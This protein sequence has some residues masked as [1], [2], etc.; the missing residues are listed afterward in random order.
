MNQLIKA[1]TILSIFF[2][3]HGCSSLKKTNYGLILIKDPASKK[4][5]V[6]KNMVRGSSC[7]TGTKSPT[8]NRAIG[9]ALRDSYPYAV[10]LADVEITGKTSSFLGGLSR[11]FQVK[12]YP[13][14]LE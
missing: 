9:V 4:I 3:F 13:V 6:K 1:S 12:G 14:I 8:L 5:K 11:C 10:G 2:L 7:R